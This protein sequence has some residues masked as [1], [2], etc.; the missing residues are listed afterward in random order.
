MEDYPY[1]E[2]ALYD[3]RSGT[4]INVFHLAIKKFSEYGVDAGFQAKA[5]MCIEMVR[6]GSFLKVE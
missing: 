1:W 4:R 5:K 6:D 2:S 3:Q